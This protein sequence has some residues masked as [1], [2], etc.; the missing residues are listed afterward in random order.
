MDKIFCFFGSHK[1]NNL[2][3]DRVDRYMS[4]LVCSTCGTV[5][6]IFKKNESADKLINSSDEGKI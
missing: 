6:I 2:R 3:M 5:L 4:R 1:L